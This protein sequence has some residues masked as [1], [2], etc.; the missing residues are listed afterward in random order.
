M[1]INETLAAIIPKAGL[2]LTGGGIRTG[3]SCLVYSIAERLHLEDPQRP[4]FAY[5]FPRGKADTLPEWIKP[6]DTEDFPDGSIVLADEAY[7]SF[8]AKD[9]SNEVNRYM[10]IFSGLAGQ[11]DILIIF[12]TQTFRKLT[13][14]TVSSVQVV[15]LK[16]PDVMMAKL[17]RSELR[18]MTAE[19]LKAFRELPAEERQQA[20]YI[21][22][23]DYE[24]L[25][26]KANTPPEF[27]TEELS[28]AWQGVSLVGG[29]AESQGTD[30]FGEP[31]G[32]IECFSPAVDLC[33]CCRSSWC[34]EH[35]A[36]HEAAAAPV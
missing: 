1:A 12:V 22:S 18:K 3:K 7:M 15:L 24:G 20:L 13:L 31:T 6:I 2:V 5:N 25:L 30:K 19:A 23:M 28:K 16:C 21:V 34:A 29:E 27:W 8:Y 26:E 14:A 11:K 4:V 36:E 35:L 10:D 17:D 9:H 32:C 33:Q